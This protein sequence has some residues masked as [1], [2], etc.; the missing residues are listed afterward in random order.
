VI[1]VLIG[2][3]GAVLT[4]NQPAMSSTGV[5][6]AVATTLPVAN[7][8][9]EIEK[10]FQKLMDEDD[11]AQGEIDQWIRENDEFA[12]K[13][14]GIPPAQLRRKIQQ[15]LDPVRKAYEDFIEQHPRHTRARV[16]FASFLGDTKD[17]DSA[18]DQLEKALALDTNSPA[19][20]NNLANIYG[21]IGPVKKAF[22]FYGKAIA[23]NP[24]EPVY[25]HN[26][27]TTVY[28]FRNDAMEYF[29]LTM[30][31]VFAKAFALYSNAMR[32][33]PDNFPL[34]S[35]V[36]QTYYGIQPLRTEEALQAWTNALHIAHDEI[37][38][39]GVYIHFARIKNMAGRFVEARAHLDAITNDM[40]MELKHRIER[41]INEKESAAKTN[42]PAAPTE[43]KEPSPP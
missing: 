22:E 20:Y 18:E 4:T 24:L 11:R 8:P 43:K 31:Q 38:R 26:F 1:A 27:G 21:H 7:D 6:G 41:N 30:E 23:L 3:L 40:Y 15:R 33:D 19:I 42:A 13:G 25:Y 28:L 39:E 35:D 16:A 17:E 37:E 5:S 34:A 36:A 2:F 14:A 9:N 12:A 10:E 29:S 32:L